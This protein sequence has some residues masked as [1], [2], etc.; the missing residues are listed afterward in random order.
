MILIISLDILPFRYLLQISKMSSSLTPIPPD[1]FFTPQ[2]SPTSS[3]SED[4]E[5]YQPSYTSIPEYYQHGENVRLPKPGD[6]GFKSGNFI[7]RYHLDF[8]L[9][10]GYEPEWKGSSY[11][12]TTEHI[13]IND[14]KVY[15]INKPPQIKDYIEQL[16]KEFFF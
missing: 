16:N 7:L 2:S 3:D 1:R 10:E 15:F 11:W 13:N 12:S 5:E 4:V 6:P 9:I 8:N 14:S